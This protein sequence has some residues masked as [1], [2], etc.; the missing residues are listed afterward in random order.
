MFY[1]ILAQAI[2]IHFYTRFSLFSSIELWQL[3]EHPE[4]EAGLYATFP[5]EESPASRKLN[6]AS[7]T[8]PR[9]A[10]VRDSKTTFLRR[11]ENVF[12]VFSSKETSA[13]DLN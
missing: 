12:C 9:A 2:H 8:K 5:Q 13:I 6:S 1:F 3:L 10:M 4:Q 11:I 7:K